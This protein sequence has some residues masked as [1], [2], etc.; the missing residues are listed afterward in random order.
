MGLISGP[1]RSAFL[2]GLGFT[3]SVRILRRITH[4]RRESERRITIPLLL[5]GA[6]FPSSCTRG[7]RCRLQWWRARR[8]PRPSAAAVASSPRRLLHPPPPSP[9]VPPHR[10]SSLYLRFLRLLVSNHFWFCCLDGIPSASGFSSRSNRILL[11]SPPLHSVGCGF[12]CCG[13]LLVEPTLQFGAPRGWL[14]G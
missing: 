1:S 9:L 2:K 8:G 10:R 3:Q 12:M 11:P 6:R 7:Q 4:G 14:N 5:G 13:A